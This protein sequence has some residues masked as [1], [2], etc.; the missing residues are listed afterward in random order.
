MRYVLSRMLVTGRNFVGTDDVDRGFFCLP[1]SS[2][3]FFR[4]VSGC[5][6]SFF[7]RFPQ[8][9]LGLWVRSGGGL[10]SSGDIPATSPGI[11]WVWIMR[12]VYPM[13]S[14]GDVLNII[15]SRGFRCM[16]IMQG[17]VKRNWCFFCCEHQPPVTSSLGSAQI[18]CVL[19]FRVIIIHVFYPCR[20]RLSSH[21]G[22]TAVLTLS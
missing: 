11:R 1:S 17:G 14:T 5:P 16:W 19:F 2:M 21:S 13:W 22:G 7:C 3:F 18:R 20:R 4:M 10:W 15:R 6:S 9:R 12:I 8:V